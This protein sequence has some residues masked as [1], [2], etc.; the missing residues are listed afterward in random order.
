MI[1]GQS[2]IESSGL[3]IVGDWIEIGAA[4]CLGFVCIIGQLGILFFFFV[5]GG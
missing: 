2:W 4:G 1:F 5:E 3:I